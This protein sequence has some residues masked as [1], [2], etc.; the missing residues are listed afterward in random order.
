MLKYVI[1]TIIIVAI[2]VIGFYF[3]WKIP[4]IFMQGQVAYS[5][6]GCLERSENLSGVDAIDFSV[7]NGNI[8]V[9]QS[10][11]HNCCQNLTTVQ[12]IAGNVLNIRENL[13]GDA[14][15]CYCHSDISI[16][17]SALQKGRYTV[18]IYKVEQGNS[19]L[20]GSKEI[21]LT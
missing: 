20:V 6:T 8:L 15:K 17:V 4:I 19:V 11:S 10:L 21:D 14:C 16:K 3:A 13:V 1:Y 5:I 18:N 7:D 2:I 9:T 12:S